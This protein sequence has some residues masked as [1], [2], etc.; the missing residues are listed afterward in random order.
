M[1]TVSL[2]IVIF[3]VSCQPTYKQGER[4][5]LARCADCHMRD[6]SGL[7]DLVPGLHKAA[8]DKLGPDLPCLIVNGL[9]NDLLP[10]PGQKDMNE[11]EIA[12]LVNYLRQTFATSTEE[13]T[14][15]ELRSQ[16]TQCPD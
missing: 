6:G 8:I 9:A 14:L 4:I 16:L 11:V 13:L 12:N 7:N 1:R 3:L 2:L 15:P 5:Y 10:M